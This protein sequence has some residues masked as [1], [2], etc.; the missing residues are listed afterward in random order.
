MTKPKVDHVEEFKKRYQEFQTVSGLVQHI[1]SRKTGW[2][3]A[4]NALTAMKVGDATIRD[5]MNDN[6]VDHIAAGAMDSAKTNLYGYFDANKAPILEALGNKDLEAIALGIKPSKVPE[7]SDVAHL[8]NPLVALVSDYQKVAE[9]NNKRAEQEI[10]PEDYREF[11]KAGAKDIVGAILK[12]E[13][14]TDKAK[15]LYAQ[16][17]MQT[18]GR[19]A[20]SAKVAGKL[21]QKDK[22]EKI[23]KYLAKEEVAPNYNLGE[24]AR[25]SLMYGP[26]DQAVEIAGT[27]LTQKKDKK[28]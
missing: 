19:T 8:H 6:S 3:Q 22:M 5:D 26:T 28:K 15:K 9:M 2:G 1:E 13:N 21:I 4:A 23:A 18:I 25:N 12:S 10:S 11:V 16:A 27:L 24:F 17:I 14:E 7:R 20:D